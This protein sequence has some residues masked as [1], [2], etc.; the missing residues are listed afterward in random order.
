MSDTP[1]KGIALLSGIKQLK[2][3]CGRTVPCRPLEN[4][5]HL[6]MYRIFFS[7]ALAAIILGGAVDI[8]A[9]GVAAGYS[10]VPGIEISAGYDTGQPMSGGQVVVYAPDNPAEPW[11]TGLLDEEGRFGFV[12]DYSLPGTWS[13]QVRQAG[14]GAM[15]HIP[16][17]EQGIDDSRTDPA[18]AFTG[19]QLAV[20]AGCVVWG[21]IGT[22]MFFTR[23]LKN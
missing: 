9:H 23:R 8:H 16:V 7:L 15:I 18:S 1:V 12:P 17:Q 4:E 11:M 22:A 20:M 21:F 13:V 19:L 6:S 3:P 10:N 2:N 14:H 5:N